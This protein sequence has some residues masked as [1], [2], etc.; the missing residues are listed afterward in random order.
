METKSTISKMALLPLAMGISLALN[1]QSFIHPGLLHKQSDFD[2]MA[3]KVTDGTDPWISGWNKL[4][5]NSHSSSSYSAK[6]PVDTVYR[7]SDGTHSENYSKLYNDIA[8][9]YANA[10]RWKIAGT[11]ANADKAIEI[12]NAWAS[13]LKA[14]K[15]TS[16]AY[17]AAGIYGYQIANAAE[18]MRNY[19]GWDTADFTIF[20]NMMLNVF[21]PLNHDFLNRH[22]NACITHYWANWDICNMSSILAIG[23]LCDNR[24]IY[25]EALDYF[26]SGAGNGAIAKAVYYIHE[27]N[28]GQWQE[29]GRDQGH[30][31][32][33]IALMGPFCEMA[34]NQGDDMYG[35]SNNR[36]RAGCEYVA[37]YNLGNSVPYITYNNCD[38]VNQTVISSSS[39]GSTRPAWEMVYNHYVNRMGTALPYT[40]QY[41]EQVRPEGGGGDY[42]STSGG[43]DQLGYGT[44]T[45]TVE[46]TAIIPYVQINGGTWQQTDSAT[47]SAGSN[48]TFS[49]Q[50]SDSGSWNWSGP[51]SFSA[52]TCEVT[53]SDIQTN[54]AGYYIATYTNTDGC[55]TKDTFTVIINGGCTPTTITQYLQINGGTWQLA[56]TAV[57]NAWDSVKFGPQPVSGGTWNWSGPNDFTATT[58]EVTLSDIQTSQTGDYVVTYTNSGG[59]QSSGTYNV[60]VNGGFLSGTYKILVSH[61]S[62]AIEVAD[63]STADGAV[64]QQMTDNDGANQ[65]WVVARISGVDYKIVNAYSGKA[66][67]VI[68]NSTSNGAL[69]EQRTFSSTDTSQVWTI[70]DFGDGKYMI[71]GKAS[72]RSLDVPGAS[73]ADGIQLEIWTSN[74]GNNQRFIFTRLKSALSESSSGKIKSGISGSAIM[75]YPNPVTDVLTISLPGTEGANVKIYNAQ[76]MLVSAKY[77][78]SN[79]LSLDMKDYPAG[80]YIIKITYE[81]QVTSEKIVKR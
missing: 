64:V 43:Y 25:N 3:T 58:R 16:D 17:L 75:L 31:T 39:R 20:K 77:T 34:W 27:G 76:G 22:N 37:K 68:G 78:E 62:K 10:L 40:Q 42:G 81:Q 1:A 57:L 61:S 67:D 29:S 56:D 32:L 71:I 55:Q 30:N 13:T 41:A 38:N 66:M 46:P 33:G 36:F 60:T 49:P 69:I 15:G 70:T 35:Y 28:L 23:V 14:I 53:L 44:L 65:Q 7:G 48:V 50:P 51:N 52:T 80:V 11:T 73:T 18:I 4:V 79:S 24:T 63:S 72:G 26:K 21:Y 12:L 8:A 54:Q 19:T 74:K 59:C 47:L 9:A 5:A 45:F 2:R 6:G